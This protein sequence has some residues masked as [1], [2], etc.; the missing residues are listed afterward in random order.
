MSFTNWLTLF[1]VVVILAGIAIGRFPILRMN[2]ATIAL[3][4]ATILIAT[5]AISLPQAYAALDMNTLVLLFAMMIINA[6]LRLAGFFQLVATQVV[7]VARS[8]RLLLALIIIAAGFLSALFLNDTIV[9]MLTPLVVEITLALR[10]NPIPYLLALATAANV[11]SV[12]TIT[13]NPQIMLIGMA[14]GIA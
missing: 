2:R 11:G 1:V 7:R 10:R 12:A 3:V 13:G 4:G 14:S 6:N 5:G 9:L 8:P